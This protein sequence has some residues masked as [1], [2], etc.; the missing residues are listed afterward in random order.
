VIRHH[1][2]RGGQAETDRVKAFSGR[3]LAIVITL[4]VLETA[5]PRVPGSASNARAAFSRRL[6]TGPRRSRRGG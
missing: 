6:I 4:L 1:I 2:F 3:V 5:P